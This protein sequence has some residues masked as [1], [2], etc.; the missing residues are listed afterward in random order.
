LQCYVGSGEHPAV[1]RVL[2][3][4]GRY[5][6]IRLDEPVPLA[7]GDR[8]VLRDPGERDT[9]GGAE[10]LDA[11]P[12]G[13]ARDALAYLPLPLEQ[14]L[15]AGQ[16]WLAMD[17][18]GPRAGLGT[19]EAA[20]LSD[21]LVRSGAAVRVGRW[22]VDGDTVTALR[23]AAASEV[24]AHHERAPLEP[25]VELAA[26]ASELRVDADRLRAALADDGELV[27]ERG[28]V[29]DARRRSRAADSAEARALL[30]AL[31][32]APFSPPEPAA[33]GAEPALVRSLTREG[34]VLDLDGIVFASGAVD[35]A[36]RRVRTALRDR[37]TVTVADVRD[38]L[39]STRKYVLPILNQLDAEGITRRRGDDRIPGP[40][41]LRDP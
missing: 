27:V 39:G 34:A 18:L 21:D 5:G 8:L 38:L 13:R 32:A 37:G 4:D 7:P 3:A 12:S 35:E 17:A 10:V 33:V 22:L 30:D 20:A 23:T 9:V 6:R 28:Y 25:G 31:E 40:T 19:T 41:A 11:A 2:D 15:L 29:R 36:R 16:R 24:R 14:R 1:L 26:L